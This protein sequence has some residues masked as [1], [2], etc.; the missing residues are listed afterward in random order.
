MSGYHLAKIEKRLY[1]SMEK[2]LEEYEE[3]ADAI[4]QNNTIMA[5]LELSD[6]Y[7]AMEEYALTLGVTMEDLRIMSDATKRAFEDGHRT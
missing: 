3:L 6:I 5:L 4:K 1:G 7:G 2:I